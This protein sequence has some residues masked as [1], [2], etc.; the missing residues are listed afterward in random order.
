METDL[1]QTGLFKLIV[2]TNTVN[3]RSSNSNSNNNTDAIANSKVSFNIPISNTIVSI[4]AA[5]DITAAVISVDPFLPA[6]LSSPFNC[7]GIRV[8]N[9]IEQVQE[10]NT[11]NNNT[12]TSICLILKA[13]KRPHS[14]AQPVTDWL[15]LLMTDY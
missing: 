1:N 13:L 2:S 8:I 9:C 10:N 5:N 15:K 3:S 6:F 12:P 11:Y 14:K 7:Y 4:N